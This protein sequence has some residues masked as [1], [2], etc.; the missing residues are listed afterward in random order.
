MKFFYI[1]AL[2]AGASMKVGPG[3]SNYAESDSSTKI[4][5]IKA[6]SNDNKWAS[7]KN[8]C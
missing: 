1:L 5:L 4:S 8:K 6:K 7:D 3:A 2:I